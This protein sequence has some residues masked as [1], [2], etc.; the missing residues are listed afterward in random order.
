[1]RAVEPAL[2]DL[3]RELEEA[4]HV[5]GASRFETFRRVLM[6]ALIPAL[7]TGFALS[8]ARG[9]GEYGSAVF[10]SGNMP[11]KSE[12]APVLIVAKLEQYDYA[13][14]AALAVVMLAIAFVILLAINILE[15]WSTKRHQVSS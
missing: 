7:T 15:R 1:V 6:P 3:K 10:V 11:L 2:V 14:A 9:L 4:A 13:G 5:L 12:I 8:F